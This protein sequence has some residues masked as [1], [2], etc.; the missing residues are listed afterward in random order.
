M[1]SSTNSGSLLIAASVVLL[2]EPAFSENARVSVRDGATYED[3][4]KCYQYYSVA[5]ELAKKLEKNPQANADQAAAFQLQGIYARQLL[6]IWSAKIDEL[7]AQRTH[8]QLDAD[9]KKAGAPIIADAN[10]AV[11]GDQGAIERGPPS[12]AHAARWKISFRKRASRRWPAGS[13]GS[14]SARAEPGRRL[15]HNTGRAAAG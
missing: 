11:K 5:A 13:A 2:A 15:Q 12:L 3:A 1:P 10:A 4:L 6:G 7:K 14:P 8:A 9:V